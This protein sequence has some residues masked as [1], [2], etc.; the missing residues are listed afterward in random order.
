LPVSLVLPGAGGPSG[1]SAPGDPIPDAHSRCRGRQKKVASFLEKGLREEGDAVDVAHDGH[2]GLLKAHIH[3]YDLLLLDVML[4]GKSGLEIVRDL[5][6]RARAT[7]VLILTARDGEDDVVPGLDAGADDYLRKP[8]G[9]D[10][11]LARIRAL[12]HTIRASD[13]CFA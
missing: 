2:D 3:D 6:G 10:E 1:P 8:F 11:V 5:R 9:F 13:T 7:P 4:P 12:L